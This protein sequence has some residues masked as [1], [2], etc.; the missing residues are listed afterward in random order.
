MF[1][2][3]DPV[4][5]REKSYNPITFLEDI[6]LSRMNELE[7]D[8]CFLDSYDKVYGE[9]RA[10]MDEAKNKKS[11]KVAYFSM[12]Y[13]VNDNLKIFSGG[14]GI[15]AG[16]YLK[17]ASDTNIN[18]VGVGLLY[19]YGYFKQKISI[20]GEQHAEYIPQNF[21]KMPILPVRDVTEAQL[22]IMVHFPG[23]NVFAKIWKAEIG[24]ITLYL[25]DT[26]VDENQEQDRAITSE[27]YGGDLEFRFKQEM[28]LGIGGIRALQEMDIRPD[29]YHC[30]EGHAAFIGLERLRLLRTKRNLKF[31]EAL[32][33]IRAS[34]LFTTHTPV[35]AGHD[36]FDENMMRV[37]MSH[38]P[39]RLKVTWE[40][41]MK[42]G[43][44][45]PDDK[46]SMSY[47]AA[48]VS[49][50]INGVSM[51][52]GKVSQD[53]FK[54]LWNGYFP[55]EN[56]VGYVTNGVHYQTWTAKEWKL[57]YE[58]EFGP[59]FLSDL[60][61]QKIWN[62]I[63]D[64]DNSKIW[65]IRQKQRT[66]LV[67]YIKDRV[68]QNWL[69]RYEDPKNIVDILENI[70]ENV[71]TIGFAR[72][73]A[74][75]KRGDLLFRNLE[76]LANILNNKQMPVQVLF[77]GKAHPNDKAGQN[78][79]KKIVEM[80]KRPEFLG[81][82]L[83]IEDYDINLAKKLVQG[84]DI[85]LNTPT[86]PQE[87]SGTSGMKAVMNG[88]LHFSVL[89]GWW[90]EGYKEN[91]GWSLPAERVYEN[92]EFQNE[93]DTQTIYHLLETEIVPLFYKRD[94]NG[95]P[96]DWIQFIKKSIA[97]IA[98]QFTTKRMIDDYCK[99]YYHKLYQ[100]TELMR[101]N[102]Y[103]LAIKIAEWKENTK[104]AWSEIEI[105]SAN[106]PDYEKNPMNLKETFTGEIEINLK[107]LKSDDI[108]VEIVIATFMENSKTK[109]YTKYKA[110]LI[111]VRNN[112]AKF[113]IKGAPEKPGFYNYA[114]RIYAKNDLLPY[115][116]DS[117]MIMW[118]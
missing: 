87:A 27:L 22:K 84:V 4:L 31:N 18:I 8:Q 5:W 28:I 30:N 97:E 102:D 65:A 19:R 56:H 100:R 35:P 40:E 106:F 1:K 57:L 3:I 50:E 105:V 96:N 43:K 47:L 117:G 21:D 92:Q 79:I 64:V 93:L 77:A 38:Y 10:Y 110:D 53:M 94:E 78:L 74:T 54:D 83:F 63:K 24:R 68:R 44:I 101:K 114:I 26:D 15:L 14:L 42:L 23:R 61:N 80:S 48:S 39:E 95:I 12:E 51:L 36:V 59:E 109:L 17:E 49:Q 82:I 66:K 20:N 81:K 86:R 111:S 67:N 113:R 112:I 55:E 88:A 98:P 60:S 45:H 91:A 70:N 69:R 104:R 46:F 16:D 13:G 90:V 25:L 34:T 85:W 32:E 33:I 116:Q 103:A 71:L 52:H 62:K 11:P 115:Q 99:Q 108:G 75:Y 76:R 41:L 6:T 9:F 73:F 89:D 2:S 7:N 118:G 58:K 29:I 107:E 37:Y 72:R